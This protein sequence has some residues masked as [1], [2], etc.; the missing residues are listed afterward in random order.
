MDNPMKAKSPDKK[1]HLSYE[2]F[3]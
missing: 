2:K 3:E 1:P